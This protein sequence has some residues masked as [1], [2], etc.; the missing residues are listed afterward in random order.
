MNFRMTKNVVDLI[1]IYINKFEAKIN[2]WLITR[3]QILEDIS[4]GFIF[5]NKHLKVQPMMYY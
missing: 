2:Y 1:S 4:Y 5:L 3:M